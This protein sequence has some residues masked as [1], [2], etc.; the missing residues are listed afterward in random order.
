M[1]TTSN[2]NDHDNGMMKTKMEVQPAHVT[3]HIPLILLHIHCHSCHI[4]LVVLSGPVTA[5]SPSSCL[6]DCLQRCH[7]HVWSYFSPCHPAFLAVQQPSGMWQLLLFLMPLKI[8]FFIRFWVKSMV[9]VMFQDGMGN[10][11]LKE[12]GIR[13]EGISE[14]FLPLYVNEIQSRRVSCCLCLLSNFNMPVDQHSVAHDLEIPY[15]Q[16]ERSFQSCR[17]A[18]IDLTV[19]RK[20]SSIH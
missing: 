13:L 20:L 11:Q 3:L 6:P 14:F 4:S 8:T 19:S 7:L 17:Q 18:G 9:I 15:N 1:V 10:L 16:L 2:I 12:D 5:C